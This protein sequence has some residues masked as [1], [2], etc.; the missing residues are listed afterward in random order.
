M[1]VT[2]ILVCSTVVLHYHATVYSHG[3][4]HWMRQTEYVIRKN[5][6]EKIRREPDILF[7][8]FCLSALQVTDDHN[9]PA[10]FPRFGC[11]SPTLQGNI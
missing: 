7:Q 3:V 11:S 9:D 2:L 6:E 5:E 4:W 1:F 10:L 8:S